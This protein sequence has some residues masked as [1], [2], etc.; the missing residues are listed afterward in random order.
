MKHHDFAPSKLE[1]IASCPWSYRNCLGWTGEEGSDAT[2]G[3]LLH[4]AIYDDTAYNLLSARERG[5]I[6]FIR[7]EHVQPYAG[8]EHYHELFVQVTAADGTILT[9]G[10]LDD[11]V[12]SPDGTYASLKDWKFGSYE[13]APAAESW[14]IKAYVCGVFQKFPKVETVYA[15]IVQ[16]VYGAADYDKQTEFKREQ[17]PELLREIENVRAA[18][19]DA[20][21]NAASP[22]A[23]NCRYCNKMA[24]RTYREK[25]DRNF[26]V[27]A[28]DPEQL[29]AAD[30][31]MTLDYADRLLCAKRE[32][33]SIMD[34]KT[35]EAKKMILAN[36]GSENF[37]VQAGRVSKRTDWKKI[38]E[39]HGIPQ[40]EID[41][42]TTATESEP[43]LVPRMRRKSAAL[44]PARNAA[45]PGE[46]K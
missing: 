15:M 16:P 44:V 8:M 35:A 31:E 43:Y 19:K 10:T 2:R 14:Q 3:T 21:E 11:L 29:A 5:M 22:S 38:V 39:A 26:A 41:A 30:T 34:A 7:A 46:T 9:E 27:F 20:N 25:M 40:D 17:L 36:G 23:S 1:R 18:A 4:T 13:V 45:K 12:I 32:I 24:C 6:D 28:I 37:R 33:E 42:A